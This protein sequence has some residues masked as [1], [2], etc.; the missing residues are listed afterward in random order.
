[1]EDPRRIARRLIGNLDMSQLDAGA[2]AQLEAD[3]EKAVE[4]AYE[5]GLED[6]GRDHWWM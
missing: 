2:K 6:G 1:M 4:E 5:E 3:V